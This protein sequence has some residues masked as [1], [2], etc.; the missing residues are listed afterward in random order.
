MASGWRQA[1]SK[2]ARSRNKRLLGGAALG[3]AIGKKSG[4]GSRELTHYTVRLLDGRVRQIST[5]QA[6]FR[7]ADCVVMER[8]EEMSNIRRVPD[9]ACEPA[10]QPVVV[11]LR[12]EFEEEAEECAAAKQQLLDAASEDEIQRA[13][14]KVEILCDG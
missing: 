13:I 3:A 12:P 14:V 5:E 10:S 2:S 9:R 8:V 4:G 1:A 7:E 11:Q 6:D